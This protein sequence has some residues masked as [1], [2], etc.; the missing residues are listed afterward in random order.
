MTPSK[1]HGSRPTIHAPRLPGFDFPESPED[2]ESLLSQWS[3][4]LTHHN[5]PHGRRDY[6][7]L[8]EFP[9]VPFPLWVRLG[10]DEYGDF[11]VT[12]MLLGEPDGTVAIGT[13]ALSGIAVN[14]ILEAA[15]AADEHGVP[16]REQAHDFTGKARRAGGQELGDAVIR[17]AASAWVFVKKSAESSVIT[18]V[19]NALGVSR[20]T[21]SRRTR[22]AR[23]LGFLDEEQA[24]I[25]ALD[26]STAAK[27]AAER[28]NID[29][30]PF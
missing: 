21:A 23:E 29:I 7:Q 17:E 30:P 26:P 18:G 13:G 20:A 3:E 12:G 5:D 24:R 27:E 8:V 9:D 19:A 16:L 6:W 15:Q 1:S 14:K 2:S 11:V 4:S 28:F 25:N 10:M 22:R